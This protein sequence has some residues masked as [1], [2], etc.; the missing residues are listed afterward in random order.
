MDKLCN[1]APKDSADT[2]AHNKHNNLSAIMVR[3]LQLY[4]GVTTSE[5]N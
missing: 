5:R 4:K 1:S 2:P 3:R